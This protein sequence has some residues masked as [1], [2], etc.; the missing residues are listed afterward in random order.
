MRKCTYDQIMEL[1]LNDPSFA[2]IATKEV[3][4]IILKTNT[5]IQH[6]S[7]LYRIKCIFKWEKLVHRFDWGDHSP[8]FASGPIID[9]W[10][11]L[12]KC[13]I[14][15]LGLLTKFA[16]QMTHCEVEMFIKIYLE[17]HV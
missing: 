5:L 12:L 17:N 1:I 16:L 15:L 11:V 2:L 10:L 8:T 4:G 7:F 9:R 13:N 14:I 3:H 6:I